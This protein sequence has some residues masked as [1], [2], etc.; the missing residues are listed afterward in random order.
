MDYTR[1]PILA[2]P[3]KGLRLEFL[4]NEDPYRVVMKNH[5]VYHEAGMEAPTMRQFALCTFGF[6]AL[7]LCQNLEG[8]RSSEER[9]IIVKIEMPPQSTWTRIVELAVPT[10]LGAGLAL[11][12]VWLTSR[13]NE[14][15]NEASRKHEFEKLNREHSFE[16]KRDLLSKVTAS[17]VQTRSALKDMQIAKDYLEFV[18]ANGEEEKDDLK[19]AEENVRQSWPNYS[20][21]K[22]SWSNQ[23]RRHR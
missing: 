1:L 21:H 5:L 20:L 11:F 2:F 6:A 19:S 10:V 8:Q 9:P 3:R 16:L 17:L 18:E 14:T 12:G 4:Q 13:K 22:P 15:A 7:S 23:L